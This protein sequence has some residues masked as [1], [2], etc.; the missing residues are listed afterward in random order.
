MSRARVPRSCPPV[1]SVRSDVKSTENLSPSVDGTTTAGFSPRGRDTRET[2]TRSEFGVVSP[3]S[4]AARSQARASGM[5]SAVASLA[6]GSGSCPPVVT[7][8]G[9]ELTA[10]AFAA[11][12]PV[13]AVGER[14]GGGGH[15]K[16]GEAALSY[17]SDMKVVSTLLTAWGTKI[18]SS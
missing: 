4:P 10:V 6:E 5:S 16:G 11:K 1:F 3:Q 13:L 14:E 15:R 7:P 12:V 2:D 8:R 17:A 9:V 18:G